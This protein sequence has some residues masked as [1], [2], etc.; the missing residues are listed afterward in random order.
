MKYS[1]YGKTMENVGNRINVKLINNEKGYLKCISKPS[2][3]PHK[4]FG[5]N[6]VAIRKRKV[7]LKLNKL[8]YIGICILDLI[9]VLT[10]NVTTNQKLIADTDSLMYKIKTEDVYEDFS[11]HTEMFDFSNYS[12]KSKYYDDSNK[13]VTGSMKDDKEYKVATKL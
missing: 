6:L 4:I 1:I 13:L 3:I 5:N 7:A 2:Y 10:I 11:S 12:T 9:K 8:A